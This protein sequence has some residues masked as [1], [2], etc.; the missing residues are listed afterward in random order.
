M[1]ARRFPP[2]WTVVEL[3]DSKRV[4][5]KFVMRVAE[6]VLQIVRRFKGQ[7]RRLTD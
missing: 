2:P 6:T 4:K 3:R 1:T 7:C 5:R